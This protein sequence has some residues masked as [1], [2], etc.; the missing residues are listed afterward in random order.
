MKRGKPIYLCDG[1]PHDLVAPNPECPNASAHEPHP[2]GY[3]AHCEWADQKLKTHKQKQCSGC[4][5]WLIWEE[6]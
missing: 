6:R 1:G 3:V 4:G 5:S 2:M